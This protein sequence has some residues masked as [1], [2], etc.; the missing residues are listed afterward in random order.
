VKSLEGDEI[1]K[2]VQLTGA[3]AVS[4]RPWIVCTAENMI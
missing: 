2:L 3:H 4:D 1:T